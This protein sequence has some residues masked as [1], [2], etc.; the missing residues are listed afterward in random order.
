MIFM[1]FETEWPKEV[2]QKLHTIFGYFGEW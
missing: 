1:L 2:S